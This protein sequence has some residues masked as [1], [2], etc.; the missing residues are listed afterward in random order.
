MIISVLS[1]ISSDQIIITV[2]TGFRIVQG[3]VCTGCTVLLLQWINNIEYSA[4]ITN[5]SNNQ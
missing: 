3:P 1:V 4:A 2:L 5:F